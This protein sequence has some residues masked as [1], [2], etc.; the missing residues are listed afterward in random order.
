MSGLSVSVSAESAILRF[1][2]HIFQ[3]K[4]KVHLILS[5]AE[6]HYLA[7]CEMTVLFF[8]NKIFIDNKQVGKSQC[9]LANEKQVLKPTEHSS[10]ILSRPPI[11]S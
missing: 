5:I 2:I 7:M 3:E 10:A 1:Q 11:H 9:S 4:C 8:K 6:A